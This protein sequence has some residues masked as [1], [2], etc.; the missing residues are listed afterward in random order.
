MGGRTKQHQGENSRREKK[1]NFRKNSYHT[2]S[3]ETR[4]NL[5]KD[6]KKKKVANELTGNVMC[7]C[8]FAA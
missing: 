3:I 2:T 6:K 1:E 7:V 4:R 8:V 5:L